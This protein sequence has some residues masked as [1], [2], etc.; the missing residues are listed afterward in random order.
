MGVSYSDTVNHLCVYDMKTDVKLSK[1]TKYQ[2]EGW[3]EWGQES[4]HA[5][6]GMPACGSHG[7]TIDT[8][9]QKLS[10]LESGSII[11]LGLVK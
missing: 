2:Q 10:I 9:A 5:C 4:V 6:A 11:G 8:V 3:R 7:P 1:G